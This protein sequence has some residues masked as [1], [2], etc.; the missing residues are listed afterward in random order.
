[1]PFIPP[2]LCEVL[3]DPARL[4]DPRYAA[5]PKFDGQR[6]QVHIVDGRTVAVYSRRHLDLLRHA[7]LAWLRDV[8]WPVAQ[9]IFDGELCGESGSDGIQAVL[10]ARG[11]KDGMTSF[12]ASSAHIA[13]RD[14]VSRAIVRPSRA[15]RVTSSTRQDRLSGWP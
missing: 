14:L 5:E 1:M 11:P 4:D 2:M 10:E 7:G 15:V 13:V 12:L 6:A 9:A 3:R 8:R